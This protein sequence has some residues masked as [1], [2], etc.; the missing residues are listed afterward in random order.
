MSTTFAI[1]G[2]PHASPMSRVSTIWGLAVAQEVS[3]TAPR[4]RTT[5]HVCVWR[6]L[7]EGPF[8]YSESHQVVGDEGQLIEFGER[9][10]V[11]VDNLHLGQ[12]EKLNRSLSWGAGR[13][14]ADHLGAGIE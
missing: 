3:R 5:R 14:V 6:I 13:H 11:G 2:A 12:G 1:S 9:V 7:L 4:P 10:V 8:G